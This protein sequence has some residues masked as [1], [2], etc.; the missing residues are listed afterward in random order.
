MKI[1][2]LGLLFAGMNCFGSYKEEHVFWARHCFVKDF[3]EHPL[4]RELTNDQRDFVSRKIVGTD[5]HTTNNTFHELQ[6]EVLTDNHWVTYEIEAQFIMQQFLQ[7][8]SEEVNHFPSIILDHS[9]DA[10]N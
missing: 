6:E 9:K 3:I 10:L 1:V 2:L 5:W 8:L 7:M 4:C